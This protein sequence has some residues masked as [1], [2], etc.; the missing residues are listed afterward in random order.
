MGHPVDVA[1]GAVFTKKRDFQVAG[2]KNLDWVRHYASDCPENSWLGRGWTV[3]FFMRLERRDDG[4][5]LNDEVGRLLL[6]PAPGGQLRYGES[7]VCL[8]ANMELR[9]ELTH[10]QILHWHIA[11]D[12]VERFCFNPSDNA[13]MPLAWIENLAG[14]RISLQYDAS[15]RPIKLLQELEQRAFELS[16]D[17]RDLITAVHFVG[18]QGRRLIVRYGYDSSRRLVSSVDADGH[19]STYTYD[20]LHRLVAENNPLGSTFQFR[21]DNAGRCVYASGN[22]RYMER[23][24][25]Y[26]SAPKMT[27][28][29]NSLG[30]VTQYLLNAAGQV[31]QEVSPLGA[32]TTTEFDE[33]GRIAK[34]IR[35]D[36]GVLGYEYDELGNRKTFIDESGGK[37]TMCYNDL[38]LMTEFVDPMGSKWI[39]EYDKRGNLMSL[40]NP[41]GNRFDCSRDAQGLVTE[42]QRPSGLV[43]RRKYGPRMRSIEFTDQIS[44]VARVEFDELGHQ[45]TL[46]DAKGMV[47]EL[48]YD[49]LGRPV[50]VIDWQGRATRL[51]YN[52]TD[53]LVERVFPDYIWERWSLDH[54][55]RLIAHENAAGRMVFE[56]DTEGNLRSVVNRAGERLT[57]MYD[58]DGR[59]VTQTLFDGRVERYEYSLQGFCVRQIK[60]DGQTI[61]MKF[62]KSGCLLA[63]TSSDGLDEK[64]AYDRNGKL[65][66]AQ[67]CDAI[68]E[69][70]RD[71]LGRITAEVQNGRRVESSFDVDNN[72][73]SRRLAGVGGVELAMRYDI[74]GRLTALID[75]AGL[76]QELVWDASNRL[77][78]RRV[79]EGAIERFTYDDARR[80]RT[81]N[82]SSRRTDQLF[83]RRFEYDK[84]QNLVLREE[85]R[86]VPT[87]FRYDSVNRLSEVRRGGRGV[88]SYQ[89]DPVGTILQTH[90]GP[91]GVSTG[92]RTLTDNSRSYHYGADGCVSIIETDAG[93]YEL[94]HNVDGKLVAVTLP[95][96]AKVKYA[97]DPLGRR[98]LKDWGDGEQVQFVWQSCDLV[99]EIKDHTVP[100]TFFHYNMAPLAQ[101]MGTRRQTPVI[102]RMGLP[103]ALL[104]ES[105]EA[106]WRASYEA[107]GLLIEEKG[108][109]SCPFRFRGQYHDRE[110]GFYYN[111]NRHYDPRLAS[112]LAPDP[113]GLAGGSNFYLYP[114]NPLLLDD[115]FALTCNTMSKRLKQEVGESEMDRFYEDQGYALVGR[116]PGRNGIDGVYHN[117]DGDPRF[118]IAEG[119]FGG[120]QLGTS[121]AGQQNSDNWV[122]SPLRSATPVA[123]APSRLD[124]AVGVGNWN[125]AINDSANSNPSSVQRQVFRLPCPG[126]PGSGNVESS[127][128]YT[129]G[130]G[131]RTF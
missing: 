70:V 62:D 72:R 8:G 84:R 48:K 104:D 37:S 116:A 74:R 39:F 121:L 41:L 21:Y 1:S 19:E 57:R 73:V 123:G 69:L 31:I 92:G 111:F 9:R 56:Y 59:M 90:R 117:P 68:V 86:L 12:H 22:D 124:D 79:P 89:Y 25:H 99:A 42:S 33:H 58:P 103:Q 85:T 97:Y 113:V 4:F 38:H 128:N 67:N 55:R 91:R 44:L 78:E 36:G 105:G 131:G 129:P 83:E 88:E 34:I 100:I 102:D 49:V 119:K 75:A 101:W 81:Q 29:A 106:I 32:V 96:G 45:T 87:E 5:L 51:H 10:F 35:P 3:P 61:D 54:F 66:L 63:R 6:F 30:H 120:S 82:F 112:Y 17:A 20:A 71:R 110:T 7:L 18:D 13:H 77:L 80:L 60:S 24:L 76:C 94:R 107:Y 43:T 109:G 15:A 64:F 125:Q 28:V 127:S 2:S 95:D 118:I 114:R 65:I 122:D 46:H 50:E 108:S 130:S 40:T 126:T 47:R 27:K 98:V 11:S 16:Y 115:P 53:D 23:R 26:L 52:A 14:H 93:R